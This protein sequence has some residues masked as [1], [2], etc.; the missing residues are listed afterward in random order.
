MNWPTGRGLWVT[1][2]GS[3]E[4]GNGLQSAV[5]GIACFV[6]QGGFAQAAGPVGGVGSVG[7]EG[8]AAEDAVIFGQAAGVG[9]GI[10]FDQAAA[11]D[12]LDGE[13]VVLGPVVAGCRQPGF[14]VG[15]FLLV[16][17]GTAA[18]GFEGAECVEGEKGQDAVGAQVAALVELGATPKA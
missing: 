15:Q 1:V 8:D 11:A 9:V 5:E 4:S 18:A 2:T 17:E 12:H 14:E 16:A 13:V 6:L 3:G 10:A 7:N